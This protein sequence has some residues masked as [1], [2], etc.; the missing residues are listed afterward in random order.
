VRFV[1][2]A[3]VVGITNLR[4]T[5]GDGFTKLFKIVGSFFQLQL[6]VWKVAYQPAS[7]E[8]LLLTMY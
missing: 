6:D 3:S 7:V 1:R 8:C 5:R 4:V 2:L